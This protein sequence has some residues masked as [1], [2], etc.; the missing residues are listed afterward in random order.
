MP[1]DTCFLVGE[2]YITPQITGGIM[3]EIYRSGEHPSTAQIILQK[4]VCNVLS[5]C[6]VWPDAQ[7][8]ES[9]DIYTLTSHINS[10]QRG[11]LIFKISY[12]D[13]SFNLGFGLLTDSSCKSEEC[14]CSEVT[15]SHEN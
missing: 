2:K 9:P 4:T 7:K 1:G 3:V 5:S 6:G 10:N 13:L 12:L 14:S 15:S 11:L 8:M